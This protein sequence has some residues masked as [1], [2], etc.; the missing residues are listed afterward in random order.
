MKN[1]YN[2]KIGVSIGLALLTLVLAV[3][4]GAFPSYAK[5]DW[6]GS[7]YN[8]P[9]GTYPVML[10]SSGYW[11]CESEPAVSYNYPTYYTQY[12][13]YYPLTASCYA[14]NAGASVPTGTAIQ[15]AAS[16]SGGSGSYSYSWSGT[17][18]LSGSG[19]SISMSYY[20]SGVKTASVT[21]YSNGQT[22]TVNCS[23]SV[24][25]YGN[26]YYY[27]Q[28]YGTYYP[29]LSASCQAN[30]TYTPLGTAVTWSA[31]ATG[32]NGY[33][34]YS[35][36]G[37][38]GISGSVQSIYYTYG[39]PGS[40]Y[41]SVTVYSNG[42]TITEPCN[43]FVNVGIPAGAT[44]VVVGSS[45]ASGLDIGCY[46]DPSTA[47]VN[48]PITWSVEV[49]GGLAPY[50]YSWTGSDG[51][52]GTQSSAIK[53]YASSG[54]KSAIVAVTSADGKTG[55]KACSNTVTVRGAGGG[56]AAP[57]QQQPAVQ[58]QTQGNALPAAAAFSLGN[59]PWGWIA[60][61][62]ILVLFSTVMY[63]LF[64]RPKI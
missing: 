53:Y 16:A 4:V 36:S 25:V 14:V 44:T 5:A 20:N 45:N 9:A 61:M 24:S 40:K 2:N 39:Q 41:A 49:S 43:S 46:A 54:A 50:T 23:G 21:V 7:N 22:I 32:G 38:D 6:Y 19:Q 59:V 10:T 33:Y 42:Q 3:S 28:P 15:W 8:C 13:S 31:S 47:A 60:V 18:G 1:L 56:T 11:Q 55:T 17:D 26:A 34:N 29:S 64:N 37:T 35:W 62:V 48:Q 63:L 30:T 57:V 12:Q 27:N 51:L 58:Q 52:S